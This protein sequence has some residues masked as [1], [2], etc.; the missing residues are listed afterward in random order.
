MS[1]D[2]FKKQAK[3]AKHHLPEI[4]AQHPPPYSLTECQEFIARIN[5]YP[6]WHIAAKEAERNDAALHDDPIAAFYAYDWRKSSLNGCC[7]KFGDSSTCRIVEKRLSATEAWDYLMDK[8]KSRVAIGD[9]LVLINQAG[10]IGSELLDK[11]YDENIGLVRDFSMI[12]LAR[13]SNRSDVMIN[14]LGGFTVDQII[15]LFSDILAPVA[16]LKQQA[17][18]RHVLYLLL[19]GVPSSE[20]DLLTIQQSVG[21]LI[22]LANGGWSKNNEDFFET[23]PDEDRYN[24]ARDFLDQHENQIPDLVRPLD[25]LL[26]RLAVPGLDT[27]FN[28][29]RRE[30][31]GEGGDEA[32]I[33]R[34]NDESGAVFDLFGELHVVDLSFGNDVLDHLAAL[35][36]MAKIRVG[37]KFYRNM[38]FSDEPPTIELVLVQK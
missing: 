4:F 1:V 3:N 11:M 34:S 24:E 31:V 10:E 27:T 33:I 7:V 20:I 21:R 9:V 12:T 5:G 36:V 18:C 35:L 25:A 15:S 2:H 22:Q 14:P 26:I 23:F 8:S 30:E 17:C 32:F 37:S 13:L 6:S 19:S 28:P 38:G 29:R 16:S